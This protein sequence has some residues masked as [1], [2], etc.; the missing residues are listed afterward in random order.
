MKNKRIVVLSYTVAHRKT[1]DTLCRL[2]AIGY[3][4]ICVYA[5][6]M[7]YVKTYQPVVKHRPEMQW[8][9]ITEELC[10][11][12]GYEYVQIGDYN[13]VQ[14]E[15]EQ[16][17]LVCGAGILPDDF[18]SKFKILNSHPGYLP[19]SRGLD[20][21]KWAVIEK[22]PI[23][24]TVH[25]IGNEVD[26]GEIIIRHKMELNPDDT[27]HLAAQRLYELEIKLLVD[28]VSIADKNRTFEYV[29]GKGFELH[30]RMPNDLEK[31]LYENFEQYKKLS[32]KNKI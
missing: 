22:Q 15:P 32:L 18:V 9:I 4:N 24:V 13:E 20:A 16:I 8:D 11:N 19:N 5:I 23:G 30:K 12:F 10:K 17:M 25:L 14:E 6:P 21:Y 1:Y 3:I 7:K 2:K 28:A 26:A 29:S 27:F 31:K